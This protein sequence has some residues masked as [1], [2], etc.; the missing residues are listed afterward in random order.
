MAED[1]GKVSEDALV[2]ATHA[3]YAIPEPQRSE[4]CRGVILAVAV[5]AEKIAKIKGGI[6][7]GV[8]AKAFFKDLQSKKDDLLP[9]LFYII[10]PEFR[11]T[12][13]ELM[14]RFSGYVPNKE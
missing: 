3:L 10:K 2:E 13:Q 1:D 14:E 9:V 7:Q 8:A 4:W 6:K 12:V 11:D 5:G